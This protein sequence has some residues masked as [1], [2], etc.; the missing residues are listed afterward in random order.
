MNQHFLL[1]PL[2][3]CRSSTRCFVSILTACS[4]V[5]QGELATDHDVVDFIM[6]QPNV[7]PRI[8]PRVL[9]TSR[10]Y[11]DLSDSSECTLRM[12][13]Y[14]YYDSEVTF[15]ED[16]SLIIIINFTRLASMGNKV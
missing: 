11:L 16:L 10:T 1:L 6:N 2:R 5:L 9:S 13:N 8:N 3:R 15:S 7:V 4:C 12:L 14:Y